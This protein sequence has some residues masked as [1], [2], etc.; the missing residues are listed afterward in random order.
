MKPTII[1]IPAELKRTSAAAFKLSTATVV[2]PATKGGALKKVATQFAA[3]MGLTL[4]KAPA[5][6]AITL[7]V[8]PALKHLGGEGYQ[9][10]SRASG[11]VIRAAAAGGVF[12]GLQSLRQLLPP[13]VERLGVGAAPV[14]E[15]PALE[16]VDKP[17]F[18]WRGAMLDCARHLFSVAEIKTFLDGMA[19]Q[20]L[21]VLH[22]HLVDDQGWRLEIRKYPKLAQIGGWR[23]QSPRYGNRKKG[24]GTPY[25]GYYTQAQVREVVAY[26]A[27]RFIT[28]V[29]EIEM[30]GHAAAAIAAYPELGNTDIPGF[31]PQVKDAWGIHPYTYAPSEKVFRFV[32]DVM[33]EV[34]ELF[35][36]KYIHIGADEALKDQWK[37]SKFAQGVMRRHKLK[38]EYGLQGWFVRRVEAILATHGRRLVGWDEINEGGLSSKATMMVW[39]DW[40][41]AHMAI[42]QGNDVVMTPKTHCYL[43]YYQADPATAD[44]P[45]AIGGL[46]TLERVY[47]LEPVPPGLPD[48]A[49]RYVL[50]VQGNLWS[51]YLSSARQLQYMA[52]PRLCALAEVGW[53]PPEQ[54]DWKD[55]K[56]RLAPLLERLSLL[57]VH[58]RPL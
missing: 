27:E 57:G 40:K 58:F 50:G 29:P 18:G 21:N 45:E 56:V 20:K 12:Y 43:D 8:D 3:S 19:L 55:F 54:K 11:I 15:V 48:A 36:S 17:R 38:D 42:E 9:L 13:Q 52:F 30:P 39:R 24:D 46:L 7:E 31:Q 47:A 32:A 14:L 44:E 22:W 2:V 10:S 37:Q 23:A 51:E 6:K 28:V 49:A 5:A 34:V 26:A 33:A 35:S 25:G 53:S 4:A 16:I 41:W 1:P